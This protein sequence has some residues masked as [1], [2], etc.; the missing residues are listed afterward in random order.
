MKDRGIILAVCSKNNENTAKEPFEKHPDM[1]LKLSDI[2]VFV[3]NWENKADNIRGI[4]NKLN[5]GID[6]MIFIDDNP[7]ERALV[8]QFLPEVL[9]PELPEDPSEYIGAICECSCF[10]TVNFSDDDAKRVQYY[11]NKIESEKNMAAFTDYKSYLQSLSME[12]SVGFFDE[13]NM[14]RISQLINKSNQFHLTTTR[15]SQSQISSVMEDCSYLGIY[16][17]LKDKFGDHGLISAVILKSLNKQEMEIDTWVMSCRVLQR[18]MEEF[19]A[20]E[21]I[22]A[23]ISGNAKILRG[24][25][26]PTKKNSLVCDLYQRLCFEKIHETEGETSWMLDL[27]G[28]IPEYEIF[29]KKGDAK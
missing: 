8:R 7:A 16:F 3:A 13:M 29:I 5:I 22:A 10:E 26:L 12:A 11:S 23:A 18:G 4:A 15:Y 9:V 17:R 20:Q 1:V 6:S 28:K 25:Y 2:T 21:I 19:I 24:K 27:T 14:Q